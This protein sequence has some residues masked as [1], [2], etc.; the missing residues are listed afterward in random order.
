VSNP[1]AP[2][3][4]APATTQQA[5]SAALCAR[6]T[7]EKPQKAKKAKTRRRRG[8]GS[9]F[10]YRGAYRAVITL[11]N[12]E[13]R[14]RDG[15]PT[16][17]SADAWIMELL[18]QVKDAA[19]PELGGPT[20]C[21]LAEM[22]WHY[23]HIYTVNK[24]GV[25]A[26]LNRIGHY[27]KAAMLPILK[28]DKS[29]N[30]RRQLKRVDWRQEAE[31]PQGFRDHRDLRLDLREQTYKAIAELATTKVSQ[32]T[33]MMVSSL[34]QLMASEGLSASTIQK[35]I[36]LLKAIFN[37]AIKEW[38]WSGFA[39]PAVG[40]ELGKSE[41]RFVVFTKKDS[42][43]LDSALARCDNPLFPLLVEAAKWT[44]ARR[45]SLL[46]LHR[47]DVDLEARTAVLRASKVGTVT[48]PLSLRAVEVLK[49][50]PEH[51]SGLFF[52][53]TAS[54]VDNAW[55]SARVRAGRPDLQFRDLRHIGATTYARGGLTA[56]TSMF[57]AEVTLVMNLP[58][59]AASASGR[60]GLSRLGTTRNPT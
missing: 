14:F 25:E 16:Y 35:E 20:K 17:A 11:V 6:K 57:G 27:L 19:R 40:I 23:A 42:E 29:E 55:D 28:L 48:I 5:T 56:S 37:K 7:G 9:V 30:G 13:E 39:N 49:R 54:A 4:T 38:S 22:M 36:A 47:N 58:P 8:T 33:K 53:M 31:L 10:V 32:I 34:A 52:P 3:T 12:G 41:S 15:F 59:P 44:L 2:Q 45:A 26:E 24:R 46:K 51:P 21:T 60:C 50:V 1:N 18:Q 43:S